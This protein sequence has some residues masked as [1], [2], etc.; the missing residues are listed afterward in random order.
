MRQTEI[1]QYDVE[2]GS[3]QGGGGALAIA[4]PIERESALA[5]RG[6]QALRNH[7]VVFNEQ[8][9]HGAVRCAYFGIVN[10]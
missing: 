7:H 5:Q 1:E 10:V 9:A 3:L 6:L 4:H 8:H 2:H